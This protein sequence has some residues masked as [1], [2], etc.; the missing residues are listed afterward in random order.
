MYD[1]LS[2]FIFDHRKK[3]KNFGL[4]KNCVKFLRRIPTQKEYD[5]AVDAINGILLYKK[6]YFK[7][8]DSSIQIGKSQATNCCLVSLLSDHTAKIV[9]L[10]KFNPSCGFD[11][12]T[13]K[14]MVNALCS[15]L[16]YKFGIERVLLNDNS[17]IMCN[18]K[19]FFS[20]YYLYLF[21]YG[22]GYYQKN[23]GFKLVQPDD[24]QFHK[25]NRKIVKDIF[26]YKKDLVK[27]VGE[28]FLA[29]IINGENI[30]SFLKRIDNEYCNELSNLFIFLETNYNLNGLYFADYEK[31]LKN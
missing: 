20:L 12:S 18:D 9:Q 26:L 17:M 29:N 14:G 13:T 28:K 25:Q 16:K 11:Q 2:E 31:D 21:K 22:E 4:L 6:Y 15:L 23:Y 3:Y 30:S 1:E 19:S 27:I 8:F 5:V 24:V 7:I 10:N